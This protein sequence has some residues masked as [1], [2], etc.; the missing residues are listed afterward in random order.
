MSQTVVYQIPP[1]QQGAF[2]H[3][4]IRALNDVLLQLSRQSGSDA[5][6]LASLRAL[7]STTDMTVTI[8]VE[9]SSSDYDAFFS[10]NWNAG[11]VWVVSQT[12]RVLVA[13]IANAPFAAGAQLKVLLVQP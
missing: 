9:M 7:V 4:Q 10:P 5:A 13:G 12:S 8:P 11:S 3:E 2:T 1:L 6:T